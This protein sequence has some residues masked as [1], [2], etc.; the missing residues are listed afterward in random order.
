MTMPASITPKRVTHG[1]QTVYTGTDGIKREIHF[2][3]LEDGA[4]YFVFRTWWD[5]E[6]KEPLESHLSLGIEAFNR[7]S[8]ML[9]QFHFNRERYV[10]PEK[11][12]E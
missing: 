7:V 4:V 5:G 9:S 8:H 12:S 2:L 11:P 3:R 6:D 1:M 10:L